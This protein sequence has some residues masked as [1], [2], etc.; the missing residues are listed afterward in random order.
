MC[1]AI[2]WPFLVEPVQQRL[3]KILDRRVVF[4]SDPSKSSGVHIG[5]LGSVRVRADSIEIGAP[6]WSKAPHMLVARDAVLKL[7]YLDLW[8]AYR[9]ATLHVRELE[10]GELDANL[11][12]RTDGRA[13]WQFATSRATMP[14]ARTRRCRPSAVSPCATG[15]SCTPMRS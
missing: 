2:G 3:A 13:S 11:E 14:R 9:G 10:A 1:E 6:E 5:L 12:R 15:M 4:G 7:G 8:R